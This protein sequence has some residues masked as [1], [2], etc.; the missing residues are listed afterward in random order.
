MFRWGS[1]VG[2]HKIL[3]Q[4]FD[5]NTAHC[6]EVELEKEGKEIHLIDALTGEL[7][8]HWPLRHVRILRDQEKSVFL[9]NKKLKHGHIEV[10]ES[11]F[12]GPF[13]KAFKVK[14]D[15]KVSL[16][17][18]VLLTPFFMAGILLAMFLSM[19][20]SDLTSEYLAHRVPLEWENGVGHRFQE[21]LADYSCVTPESESALNQMVAL[22]KS[23]QEGSGLNYQVS[24][25]DDDM[26]N[27]YA[28]P[29]GQ[30]VLLNGLVRKTQTP[31]ELIGVIAHEIQHVE[32]RHIMKQIIRTT[33]MGSVWNIAFGDYTGLLVIDP[34]S[35][36]KLLSMSYSQRDEASAD[37]GVIEMLNGSG[38]S[39]Q[40]YARFFQR[41]SKDFQQ[42]AQLLSTHPSSESRV[43]L[44]EN[45]DRIPS[46][47]GG[48]VLSQSDW[49]ALRQACE[50][51]RKDRGGK[52][53]RDLVF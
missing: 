48:S 50:L 43:E 52:T 49:M 27:A 38:L 42:P 30:I 9:V 47:E 41:M 1:K 26:V 12:L 7:V 6:H 16:T 10:D 20:G 5:G 2:E 53:L 14:M 34:E 25:L 46:S 31:E 22:L 51:T 13:Q 44:V 39:A 36:A 28:L 11:V 33:I 4:Y 32:Q 24:L 19:R 29:G 35:L 40:G 45:L 37:R 23:G 8:I 3:A 17:Q 15:P 21:L 18:K